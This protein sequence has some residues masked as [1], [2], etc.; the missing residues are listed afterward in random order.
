MEK[1]V[2]CI[3]DAKAET[4][5]QWMVYRTPNEAIRMFSDAVNQ[6][7]SLLHSHP[8]DFSLYYVGDCEGLDGTVNGIEP[9]CIARGI[10]VL[11]TP[12]EWGDLKKVSNDE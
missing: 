6:E 12:Q 3:R 10:D 11:K 7:G 9:T 8:E 1:I 4:Y 5:D 2:V